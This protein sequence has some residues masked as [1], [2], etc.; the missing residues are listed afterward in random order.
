MHIGLKHQGK[1]C[2][3]KCHGK[4]GMCK[5][6]G[7]EG[8]CCMKGYKSLDKKNDDCNGGAFGGKKQHECVHNKKKLYHSHCHNIGINY[9]MRIKD[10][11][12]PFP[13]S[14]NEQNA[15]DKVEKHMGELKEN[16][17][18]K[19]SFTEFMRDVMRPHDSIHYYQF[20]NM[21]QFP[22]ASYAPQFWLHHSFVDKIFS[23]W[24][25]MPKRRYPD[26]DERILDPFG[27][28]KHNPFSLT[29]KTTKQ[30]WDYERNL[31]YQYDG[32]GTSRT[33]QDP[34]QDPYLVRDDCKKRSLFMVVNGT[35]L[36]KQDKEEECFDKPK[37]IYK[38]KTY[39]GLVVPMHVGSG[40]LEYSID[41]SS[42]DLGINVIA[43]HNVA[44]FGG[45]P[46][47]TK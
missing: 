4:E 23:D 39:V 43:R 3:D 13:N 41:G 1:S 37:R 28:K 34:Y 22:A 27:D 19:R 33:P 11:Y 38:Y 18:E 16:A 15:F 29:W 10:K 26:L 25:A 24:Q 30:A 5:W 9:S 20:C 40:R 42:D 21:W 32:L 8:Y 35:D 17:L 12:F 46:I 7:M 36:D 45:N 44:L 47:E 31:C 2:L 14:Q 6:C